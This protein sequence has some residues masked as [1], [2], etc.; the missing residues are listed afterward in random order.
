LNWTY[1]QQF[2][3]SQNYTWEV[4]DVDRI[5]FGGLYKK[6][7]NLMFATVFGGG[8]SAAYDKPREVLTLINNFLESK[9]NDTSSSQ[10]DLS[11]ISKKRYKI[12]KGKF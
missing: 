11:R 12:L 7:N 10:V 9:W 8:H 1:S 5:R 3:D 6:Y 4:E 2:V